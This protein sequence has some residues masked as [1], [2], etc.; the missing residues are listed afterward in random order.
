MTSAGPV[1]RI[2]YL[3]CYMASW[4]RRRKVLFEKSSIIYDTWHSIDLRVLVEEV[5]NG[6]VAPLVLL[7]H[8]VI[9]Q[10]RTSGHPAVD[11][12]REGLDM[13]GSLE[14]S[15]EGFDILR[16]LVLGG[17]QGH[18]DVDGLGVVGVDHGG[19]AL[20]GG[21]EGLVFLAGGEGSDLSTPAMAEDGPLEAAIG[22]QLV[23]L[24]HDIGD[25][26]ES[27][28][29]AGLGLEEVAELLLVVVGL[30]G[31]PRDVG[32]LALEEVGHKDAVF[33]LVGGGQDVGALDGLIEEAEDV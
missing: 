2:W 9:L 26:G 11:L 29:G 32:G 31:E 22:G 3:A 21:L 27:V 28:G 13:V 20:D 19:V 15:F 16:G 1:F 24:T 18:G 5:E 23:G 14:V 30:R 8:F 6:L 7:A 12:G 4:M 25:A 17:Q 33:L 10:V